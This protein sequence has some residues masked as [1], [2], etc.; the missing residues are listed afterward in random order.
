MKR[1]MVVILIFF[2]TLSGCAKDPVK[3]DWQGKSAVTL[4]GSW[5]LS[6]VD[7]YPIGPGEGEK[8]TFAEST[9]IIKLQAYE[10]VL[11]ADYTVNDNKIVIELVEASGAECEGFEAGRIIKA[12]FSL[13]GNELTMIY[14]D[15]EYGFKWTCVYSK[16]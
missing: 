14:T 1:N 15:V 2:V 3:P 5:N 13:K 4:N 8:L 11:V 16:N 9:L 6:T 12:E 10:C 7:G